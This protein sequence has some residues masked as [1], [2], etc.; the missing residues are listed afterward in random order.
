MSS[1][2]LTSE[3]VDALMEGLQ[4]SDYAAHAD[5]ANSSDVRAFQFGL[6]GRL[7]CT[8]VNQ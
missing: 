6:D 3:E 2:K 5:V 7:L 8:A 1:R 4:A